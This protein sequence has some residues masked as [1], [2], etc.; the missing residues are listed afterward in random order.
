MSKN[1]IKV[2]GVFG[3]LSVL[4]VGAYFA[5][6]AVKAIASDEGAVAAVVNGEKIYKK[7]VLA[8]LEG[9]PLQNEEQKPEAY[10]YILE[11]IV[12]DQLLASDAANS[13]LEN[14]PEVQERFEAL[15]TQLVNQIYL[16]RHVEEAVTEEAVKAEYEKFKE[17]NKGKKEIR[18]R[19]ILVKTEEEAKKIIEE[20]NGGADFVDIAQQKSE[21]KASGVQGGDLGYF[22]KQ[23]MVPAFSEAAFKLETGE[24]SQEPVQTQFGWHV[25]KVE[26]KRDRVVP[27]LEKVKEAIRNKLS[28][29]AMQ[30]L[31]NKLRETAEIETFDMEGNPIKLN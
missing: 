29:Q 27:E 20:L 2:I 11:R 7:D 28:Q 16:E 13:G 22:G 31:V 12:N 9:M 10:K 4:A 25:I 26:D 8:V 17:A 6:P 23:D 24:I 1:A 19:H 15:K 14:D 5:T 3:V 18:A 21:D 30:E